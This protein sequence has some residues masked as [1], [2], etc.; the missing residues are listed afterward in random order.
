MIPNVLVNFFLK[1]T[2]ILKTELTKT[3]LDVCA[4][5]QG[6]TEKHTQTKIQGDTHKHICT[7]CHLSSG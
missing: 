7:R 4:C 3:T 1:Y 6:H 2:Y 5:T